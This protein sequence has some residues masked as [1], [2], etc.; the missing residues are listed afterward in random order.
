MMQINFKKVNDFLTAK[1][2][3]K[4]I[5]KQ[6]FKNAVYGFNREDLD[7]NISSLSEGVIT[8]ENAVFYLINDVTVLNANC[9]CVAPQIYPSGQTI[10]APL[11][12]FMPYI[13]FVAEL[14]DDKKQIINYAKWGSFGDSLF[15][16]LYELELENE[17]QL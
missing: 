1:Y 9:K 17:N 10:P 7:D 14:S 5:T 11:S 12:G 8:S 6:Q 4:I 16:E 15:E 2:K 3:A 13:V